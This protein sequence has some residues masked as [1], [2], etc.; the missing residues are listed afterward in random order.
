MARTRRR[1][2][3]CPHRSQPLPLPLRRPCCRAALAVGLC[4]A[5]LAAC[6]H[7]LGLPAAHAQTSAW[8]RHVVDNSSVGADGV[9]LADADG[10]GLLDIA[11]AWEEGGLVRLYFNPGPQRATSPW[12]EVTVG[13]VP[14]GEDAVP[15]DLD[16]DGA[17]DV[18][19]CCE[20]RRRTVYVHWAPKDP[21]R[22]LDAGA[23]QTEAFPA[24]AGRQMWMYCLP[25]DVDGR[26]GVDLVLAAKGPGAQIGWLQSPPDPRDLSAWKWRPLYDA[27][28]I[29]SL[30]AR[31]VD[32]DG[33]VDIVATDRKGARS[34]CLWIE[35]P[36]PQQSTAAWTVHRVGGDGLD[37]MFL[38]LGD[39]DGD[40][41]EDIVL[42]TR[43][44][45]LL[46]FRR[47]AG[48]RPAWSAHEL[49]FPSVVTSGKG[50]AIGD[51]DLDGRADLVVSGEPPPGPSNVAWM[52]WQG[53]SPLDGQWRV[54]PLSGPEGVK[55]DQ[56]ELIDLDGDGDLDVLTT[57]ERTSLGV[58]WY[59]NPAR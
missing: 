26:H 41:L 18:V 59:E 25:L 6:L 37:V 46:Y 13:T 38:A 10:D 29:M 47:Q 52:S 39:L 34:G 14:S 48:D 44:C 4:V 53:S 32:G 11:T 24:L 40:G 33:D 36:G 43:D 31:D 56:V 50:V 15:V 35:H 22:R 30:V 3:S 20:G 49:P 8:T 57:E 51:L 21:A 45:R 7:G 27:G 55:F 28:W 19:S 9:R 2:P 58:V 23:W 16:G 1:R 42:P 54:Q 5:I 12:P 17:V